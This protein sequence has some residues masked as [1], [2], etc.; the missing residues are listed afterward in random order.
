M[1]NGPR[2]GLSS[3]WMVRS[4]ESDGGPFGFY[5]SLVD[6]QF[7]NGNGNGKGWHAQICEETL[8]AHPATTGAAHQ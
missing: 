7:Q 2:A 8:G 1:R 3:L 6:V 4:Q 5:F